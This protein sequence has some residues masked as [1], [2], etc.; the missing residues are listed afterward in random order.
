MNARSTIKD[1][2]LKT[3]IVADGRQATILLSD[4]PQG[5]LRPN[6]AVGHGTRDKSVYETYRLPSSL[7]F[8]SEPELDLDHLMT[9]EWIFDV[10]DSG[11]VVVGDVV[12]T[13]E[14]LCE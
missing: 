7:F 9:I 11:A 10:T 8:D 6:P 2:N 1:V 13:N 14:G 3:G 5:A 4:A 12:F